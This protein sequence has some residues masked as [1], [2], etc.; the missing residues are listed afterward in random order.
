[1]TAAE[2]GASGPQ[3]RTAIV[4][5]THNTRADVLECLRSLR[6]AGDGAAPGAAPDVIVVDAGSSDDTVAAVR[7]D[8]PDVRV[9]ELDNV[10][11]GRAANTGVRLADADNV[12]IANADVRLAPGVVARLAAELASE[13]TLAAV[14]P[15]VYDLDGR[16]QATARRVPDP[17]VAVLHG[18]L[19]RVWADNPMTRRYHAADT[20]AVDAGDGPRMRDA[21]WLSGCVVAVRRTAFTSVGGFDPRYF[22]YM[23]DVDLSVR[24][25]AAGWRLRYQPG[26]AVTHVGGAST[27]SRP[28]RRAVWHATSIDR[29][30]RVHH[31]SAPARILHPLLRLGLAGWVVLTVIA[32]IARRAARPRRAR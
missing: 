24:L 30:V 1:M 29:Y 32:D 13:E 6:E 17:W 16:L 19:G 8:A 18:L 12:V 15:A 11:F 23:E 21:E 26:I 27:R 9:V 14:G 7:A 2:H 22:L 3:A 10:G 4:I 31:R 5:V 25:R 20:P 28:V